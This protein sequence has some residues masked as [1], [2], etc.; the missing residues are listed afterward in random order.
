VTGSGD[1]SARQGSDDDPASPVGLECREVRGWEV[2]RLTSSGLVLDIVPAL[3]GTITSLARRSDAAE[4]LWATPWG[5]RHHGSPALPG[6]SEA[7]MMDTFTGGWSSVF[8]NGGDSANAHGVEWG[9]DGELR[10]TWLDW[11]QQDATLT[12]TG[13]LARSPFAITKTITLEEDRV[14][15]VETVSNVGRESV[16]VMWASQLNLGGALIGPDTVL[17]T[18][19][20]VV[21]PDPRVS[22][23]AGYDDLTPWPRTY[24]EDDSMI[25]LRSVPGPTVGQ[26]RLAYLTD[27]SRPWLSVSRPSRDLAVE[28][29][30]DLDVWPYVWYSLEAGGRAGFPWYRAAY[31]LALTP[32]SSWPAHGLH[33]ARRVSDSTV[34]MAPGGSRT[35]SLELVLLR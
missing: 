5:L 26:S 23:G 18:A 19:A 10:L 6:T 34:W 8:P 21:R 17:D 30:W 24:G 22:R 28:L 2:L 3:G 9:Y 16:E 32:A 13:R 27:F 1:P 35:S 12:L 29:T 20:S 11:E 33:D 7:Q 14:R 31:F 15:L 25:N 4:L